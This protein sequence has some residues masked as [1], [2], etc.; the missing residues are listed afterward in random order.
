MKTVAVVDP[1]TVQARAAELR[2][3]DLVR[4]WIVLSYRDA[5][6][7]LA[8][9]LSAAVRRQLIDHLHPARAES[10]EE[11]LARIGDYAAEERIA[12]TSSPTTTP[13][14]STAPTTPKATNPGNGRGSRKPTPGGY[15]RKDKH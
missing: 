11:L 13:S 7:L 3:H 6:D 14:C 9:V 12:C 4:Y 5:R 8:G 10:R 1:P 15:N 2:A